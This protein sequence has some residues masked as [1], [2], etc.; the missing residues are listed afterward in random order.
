MTLR[1]VNFADKCLVLDRSS[2]SVFFSELSWPDPTNQDDITRLE[3]HL[4]PQS[5]FCFKLSQIIPLIKPSSFLLDTPPS[6]HLMHL[7]RVFVKH[8]SVQLSPSRARTLYIVGPK[9]L[10]KTTWRWPV[11][12]ETC[13]YLVIIIIIISNLSNDRSKA[14]S[15]TIPPHSAI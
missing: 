6:K 13:S 10:L 14:S 4:S 3:N 2:I 12:A 1:L 7:E 9:I 15:K 5:W 11:G 8:N